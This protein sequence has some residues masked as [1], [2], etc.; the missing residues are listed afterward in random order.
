VYN[1]V[2]IVTF[3]PYSS[4]VYSLLAQLR[5]NND[6]PPAGRSELQLLQSPEGVAAPLWLSTPAPVKTYWQQR[7]RALKPD[8]V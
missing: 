7:H 5:W 8:S 2:Q 4:V 6:E 3:L 1:G